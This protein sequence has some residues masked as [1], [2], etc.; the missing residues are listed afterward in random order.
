MRKSKCF[1]IN[2]KIWL[3]NNANIRIA[4]ENKIILFAHQ[5]NNILKS[6]MLVL[7][8]YY[9]YANKFYKKELSIEY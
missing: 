4:L 1:G 3:S 8:K 2:L 9:I 6:Y 7:A 5:D